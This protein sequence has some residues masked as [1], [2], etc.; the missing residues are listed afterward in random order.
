MS[1]RQTWRL[2]L[3]RSSSSS[4]SRQL[5]QQQQQPQPG[6]S[7][8]DSSSHQWLRPQACKE[9]SCRLL[10]SAR[11]AANPQ[12]ATHQDAFERLVHRQP[13]Q[14]PPRGPPVLAA[15]QRGQ[16]PIQPQHQHLRIPP[17]GVPQHFPEQRPLLQQHQFVPIQAQQFEARRAYGLGRANPGHAPQEA[18]CA[19]FLCHDVQRVV[20][21]GGVAAAARSSVST[22]VWTSSY[23]VL[24]S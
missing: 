17:H 11:H 7:C 14:P 6:A 4:R 9:C 15:L 3:L 1:R 2:R 23:D 16:Q 18:R 5:R 10:S 8:C 12:L 22:S 20:G 13:G 21:V 24:C 19:S